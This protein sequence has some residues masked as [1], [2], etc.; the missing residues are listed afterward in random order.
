MLAQVM[1]HRQVLGTRGY[2][3]EIPVGFIVV[4]LA[5]GA[6]VVV[7]P[8]VVAIVVVVWLKQP[9]TITLRPAASPSVTLDA[10]MN[11]TSAA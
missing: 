9:R 8:G 5:L 11:F 10:M 1:A 3:Q 6:E 4:A 2:V 7:N